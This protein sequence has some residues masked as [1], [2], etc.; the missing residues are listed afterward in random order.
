MAKKK[1]AKNVRD[2][3]GPPKPPGMRIDPGNCPVLTV[4]LLN[5]IHLSLLKLIELEEKRG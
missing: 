2:I 4:R 1:K 3:K 5:Q